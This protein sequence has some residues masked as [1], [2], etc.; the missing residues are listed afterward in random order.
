MNLPPLSRRTVLK[1]GALT[2]GAIAAGTAVAPAPAQARPDTGVSAYAFPLTAVRLGSGPFQSNAARTQAYLSFL[3][4]DRLLHMFR[5]TAGLPSTATPCGGWES[6]S[7]ELRGHSIGHVLTALAQA[8]ASTG[9]AAYKS[10]G[11]YLV[12]QLGLCQ[13]ANGYLSAYPESFFDRLESG[14]QVWAPYYTL[15][16]IVAGLLDMH[17]LAGNAQAL[18]ILTRKAAWL[19]SRNGRLTY[20]QRQQLLR[21]E[22]GGIGETLVN[23]YQL[24]ENP[25][26]LTTAQYFDH[27]QVLDPLAAGV[28]ALAGFHANTQIPKALAAIRAYHATGTTRYRD[29]AV[30]FWNFVTRRHSYAIGGNSNGEYFKAPDRIAAELSDS[31]CECCNT[32][33]MLKL[34]RQL[35]FT[36]PGRAAELMDFYEKALYNHLLGAQNPASTHG[37]HCYY[38]PLRPGGIK[39]YSNDYN[40]F[41]CCHGTGMETNTRFGDSVYFHNGN[42]LY[43]NLF[44]ASTLT[45]PGRGI[46]V[47]QDTGYP[48]T[49]SSRLTVTG[50]GAI[51]LRVR[52]P[53]WAAGAEVRVNGAAQGTAVPGTY[54]AV[55]RTWSTGDTVDIS[56]PMALA[57]EPTPDNPAVRSVRHGPIVLAGQ[58]GSTDLA[59]LPALDP[60]ALR[61]TANP[62][63]YTAGSVLLRPFYLTHGQRYTV[64]WNVASTPPPLPAFVAHYP[65]DEASGNTAAD[66]TGNGRTATLSGGAGR[67]TGRTGNAV[68]LNGTTAHVGLPT[69][70]L[71]GAAAFTVA[72][73]VRLDT[74]ATW[75]R[76]FDFGAGTGAY[77]FLT[78]RSSAG[79]ARYAITAGGSGAEQRIDAPAALPAGTWTHVAVTHTGNLGVLY[80][81]GAEVARNGALTVRPSAL[82][83]TTQNWIGRSQYAGDPYLAAAVDDF[84]VYSRALSAAELAQLQ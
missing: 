82:G 67:T 57:V 55:S 1:S 35:F 43:V 3:D 38:V 28:D 60:A 40:N 24:S 23:L 81:N 48:Q 9:D 69:G 50:S 83:T 54:L 22:F 8:Y 14:Q 58:Y 39:T 20:D 84:R 12:A 71:A 53:S 21:T 61:P 62:L 70:I 41:T 76:V 5:V 25:V 79:T 74:V 73:W 32:Y 77:L 10:K 42:T 29:I 13:R 34:T 59:A 16:K 72:A 18:T 27:A 56:L 44:I 11:D 66:A 31:T 6:P 4:P 68:L 64:Y 75:A 37:H 49:P 30:N 7:T 2:A 19:Q 15:H 78:P 45:W 46:T 47:R 33:N 52:I 26:H 80:V 51:D 63:E 65:F 17:Q 36:D